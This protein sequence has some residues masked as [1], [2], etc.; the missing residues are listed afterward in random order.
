MK[1]ALI[2]LQVF[3]E[4]AMSIGNSLDLNQM[5]QESLTAYLRKLNCSAGA[6]FMT[7]VENG[8]N[9][10]DSVYRFNLIYSIPRQIKRNAT[11]IHALK[12]VPDAVPHSQVTRFMNTLPF[13]GQHGEGDFFHIMELPGFGLL[14]LVKSS[15]DLEQPMIQSLRS[16]NEK[17]AGS[18][19]ACLQN[20][21]VTQYNQQLKRE[22]QERRRIEEA[23]LKAK[24]LEAIGTLAGGVAHD[25]NNLLSI[26]L[27]SVSLARMDV[28]PEDPVFARLNDIEKVS[29]KARD[30]TQKFITFSSGGAPVRKPLSVKNLIENIASLECVG[31]DVVCRSSFPADLWIVDA[32]EGQMK[33]VFHNVLENAKEAMPRGGTIDIIAE[34][35]QLPAETANGK[36]PALPLPDGRYIKIS[37]KDKG[38]GIP[39]ENLPKV[40]DPYYSSKRKGTDK[41][42]GLGLTI[43]Y[44]VVKKH[45]GLIHIESETGSGT[46]V[47][48]YLPAPALQ[49]KITKE[50]DKADTVSAGKGAKKKI[51]MMDDEP[52]MLEMSREM[53]K[54][55]GYEV[56]LSKNGEEAIQLYQQ[57]LTSGHRFDAVILDLVVKKGMDGETAM[58]QLLKI[59]PQVTAIVTSGYSDS[60]I[61]SEFERYGF[62]GA[63]NKPFMMNQFK[64]IVANVLAAS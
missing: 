16:L 25:F 11:C 6:V 51:L 56:A 27:G 1:H 24:K 45:G 60:P 48:I 47:D 28:Q 49:Q 42:M 15:V 30:L 46:E 3:Y 33:Q 26:I 8:N 57:S 58:Q 12:Q 23:L 63:I 31:S 9:E 38:E 37:I 4:I 20:Q 13:N 54:R 10:K 14:L 34:N 52:M 55:M 35:T 29:L 64:E 32:D 40:F 2:K 62:K 5:L 19:I 41:G 39:K 61:I 59:D 22:I 43:A 44:S 18:C 17:L 53:L 7:D 50:I 21:K 36:A